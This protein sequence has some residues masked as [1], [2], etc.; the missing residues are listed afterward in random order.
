MDLPT[1]GDCLPRQGNRMT[2]ALGRRMLR[3]LRWRIEG[4]IPNREKILAIAAPHTTGW[5]F[6]IALVALLALGIRVSWM[7]ADW[8]VRLPLMRAIGGVSVSRGTRSGMVP[9][10]VAKFTENRRFALGLSPE[11]SRKKVTPWKTGFYHIATGANVP[12]LLIALDQKYKRIE[13]GPLIQP[14]GNY[15]AD[16]ELLIKPFFAGFIDQVPDRFSF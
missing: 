2:R 10:I 9:Q 12:I 11:G 7:G 4:Q 16:M 13:I 15:E 1:V 8:V 14:T 5:D 3:L 6:G